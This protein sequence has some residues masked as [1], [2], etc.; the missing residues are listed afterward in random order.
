M[1][2]RELLRSRLREPLRLGPWLDFRPTAGPCRS[3][4]LAGQGPSVVW[5]EEG[6][7]LA[8]EVAPGTI[9]PVQA[10]T[11]VDEPRSGNRPE[12]SIQHIYGTC[13]VIGPPP[14]PGELVEEVIRNIP[15]IACAGRFIAE[16][17]RVT[18]IEVRAR[19]L[20]S[21]TLATAQFRA[22]ILERARP[23]RQIWLG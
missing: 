8:A 11:D 15:A 2:T 10:T 12:R 14:A 16:S 7:E 17:A 5:A 9:G 18:R 20:R 21:V 1:D 13:V 22:A 19:M 23:G 4:W 3:G 6:R